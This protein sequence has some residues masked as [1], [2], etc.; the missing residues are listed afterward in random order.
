[1]GELIQAHVPILA[2]TDTGFAVG[3]AF[4]AFL[5]GELKLLVDAGMTPV[6]A[7]TAA[8]SAPAR[9]FHLM[10]RGLIRPGM[11]ADLLLV[12]GDPTQDILATRSIVAVWKKGMRIER[13]EAAK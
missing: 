11:R 3:P 12:E 9:A 1:M 2:G 4:G 8:T 5:Q 7:L 13:Q 6:Q 10:D